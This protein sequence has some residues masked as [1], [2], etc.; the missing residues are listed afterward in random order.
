MRRRLPALSDLLISILLF[1]GGGA[2]LLFHV[3]RSED[4]VAALVG[5]LFGA[6]ALLLGNWINRS[7]QDRQAETELNAKRERMKALIGSDLVNVAVGY[8]QLYSMMTNGLGLLKT[9][10]TEPNGQHLRGYSPRQMPFT[11]ALAQDIPLLSTDEVRAIAAL[12]SNMAATTCA[13]T[14]FT[15]GLRPLK[16]DSAR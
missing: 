5:A 11:D 1:G 16:L 3:P 15:D 2:V 6:G 7:N 12:R 9:G 4:A 14:E 10:N 8:H 13:I